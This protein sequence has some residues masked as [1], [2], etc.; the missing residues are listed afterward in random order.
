MQ[1]SELR[2]QGRTFGV[3]VKG[4]GIDDVIFLSRDSQ[5]FAAGG[6]VFEGRYGTV[7]H[8]AAGMQLALLS[9]SVL[10]SDGV[11]V[12]SS[13]PAVFVNAGAKAVEIVA[14]GEGFVEVNWQ[15]KRHALKVSGRVTATLPA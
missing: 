14:E 4:E 15:G 10:E 8:R 11:R 5:K 2:A 1:A 3:K 6:V 9:G 7:I 13:G 12:E